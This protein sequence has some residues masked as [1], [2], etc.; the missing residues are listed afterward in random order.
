M[1]YLKPVPT[2]NYRAVFTLCFLIIQ[3]GILVYVTLLFYPNY[4]K[5]S[6]RICF[7][8][9]N[10]EA[11]RL[12][13]RLH[14]MQKLLKLVYRKAKVG[15]SREESC[16]IETAILFLKKNNVSKTVFTN[17]FEDFAPLGGRDWS[18]KTYIPC[19]NK[20]LEVNGTSKE[21]IRSQ[22]IPSCVNYDVK[23]EV[24][25]NLNE[26]LK[27]PG[28]CLKQ[29]I[30]KFCT[31]Q[32]LVPNILHYIWLGKGKF[33][34]IFFVSIFS[35][36]KKQHPCLI[37][38]YYDTLPS[39]KWWNLL[40]LYVSNIIP[41]SV[42]PPSKIGN[43][44]IVFLEHKSDILRLQI[45]R[46]Y[47]GIYLDTDQLLL[48]SLDKFRDRECTMGVASDGYLGSAVIIASKNSAFIKKWM[49]SYS[50]YK[51]NSWGQNSVIM[52]TKLAKQ[53]PNLIH[54]E[55]H[56]CSF[57]PYPTYLFKQNYKWSH[58]YGL[59][60]YKPGREKQLKQ[61]N[62]SSIRKLNNTLGAAFRFVLFDDKELCL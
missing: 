62:F 59:H 4:E 48:T 44:K 55:R 8:K 52:A 30:D 31:T 22:F 3:L 36:Y 9:E 11:Q 7:K 10:D 19:S 47:G 49:D 61:L 18:F 33:E 23:L 51:P 35:G 50:A 29:V 54:L 32:F 58:S 60:I 37:F 56:Y 5:G 45:L 42:N 14:G 38:L 15:N 43:R 26:S 20:S 6:S 12:K 21:L 17:T 40:L 41:V 28:T 57:Y 25:E 13:Y 39:G 1:V 46:E 2:L 27:F 24:R 34:F 53:N 16:D